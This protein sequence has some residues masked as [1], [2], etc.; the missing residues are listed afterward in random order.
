MLWVFGAAWPGRRTRWP[1]LCEALPGRGP[2]LRLFLLKGDAGGGGLERGLLRTAAP[3][4]FD[5][6][7]L[8]VLEPGLPTWQR[9]PGRAVRRGRVRACSGVCPCGLRGPRGLVARTGT[10][11]GGV[12]PGGRRAGGRQSLPGGW[13][14]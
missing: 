6:G 1:S 5:G 14:A 11:G 13:A 8:L 12:G 2:F 9:G 7:L 3:R 4:W 10:G